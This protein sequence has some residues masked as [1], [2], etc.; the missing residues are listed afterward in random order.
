M[1]VEEPSR[2]DAP[3]PF[4]TASPS[5][6][7]GKNEG[8]FSSDP[9][10][11][12]PS[13]DRLTFYLLCSTTSSTSISWTRRSFTAGV[14]SSSFD[15]WTVEVFSGSCT[16]KLAAFSQD[17]LARSSRETVS[18]VSRSNRPEFSTLTRRVFPFSFQRREIFAP[19]PLGPR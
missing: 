8:Q 18:C 5:A 6:P 16:F 7:T 10:L 15:S 13:F 17:P 9:L 12:L 11:S 1:D 3:S 2:I 4:K 14:A 19:A